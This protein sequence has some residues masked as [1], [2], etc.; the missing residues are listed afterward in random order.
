M[1][2]STV[3]AFTNAFNWNNSA[4]VRLGIDLHDMSEAVLNKVNI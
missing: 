3:E 2:T 1:Q 4:E